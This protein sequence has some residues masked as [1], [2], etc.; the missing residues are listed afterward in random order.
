MFCGHLEGYSDWLVVHNGYPKVRS[1]EVCTQLRKMLRTVDN[2]CPSTVRQFA[3]LLERNWL[4]KELISSRLNAATVK[5]YI[6][7]MRCFSKYVQTRTD[8]NLAGFHAH[9][10]TWLASLRRK[11]AVALNERQIKSLS[12]CVIYIKYFT[13]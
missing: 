6:I 1:H 5:N 11:V 3:L 9:T 10:D 4:R 2:E 12:K 8:V 13:L 7:Y